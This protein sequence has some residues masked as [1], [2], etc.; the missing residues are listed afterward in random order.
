MSTLLRT[1]PNQRSPLTKPFVKTAQLSAL[2]DKIAD[3]GGLGILVG[4]SVRDH[5][6][7]LH[8]KDLD[9]EVYGLSLAKLESLLEKHFQVVAVGKAFGIFKVI[10]NH[11]GQKQSFDVALPRRENKQG[12]GHKGFIVETDEAMSFEEAS[13]RR[14]FTVNAMGIDVTR[15]ELLDAHGGKSDLEHSIL[16]HVSLAF[17]EDPLRVLRAAQ[18]CARFGFS[19]EQSTVLLCQELKDELKTLSKERI[20]EEMKKLLFSKKPS[21]GMSVLRETKAL[22]LFP[23]LEALIDCQQDPLWHPEGDVWIH[24]LMVIDEAA[25]ICE[26]NDLSYEDKLIVMTGALCHDLGKPATTILKDDRIKSP[27]HDEAGVAITESLLSRMAFP[28]KLT[29]DI[30]SLVREHL[31]PYQLYNKRDNVSDGAIRRLAHRVNIE[32]LLLVSQADFFGRTTEEAKSGIDPSASWL[33]DRVSALLGA[34]MAPKPLLLGRHLIDLGYKP[35]PD[36]SRILNLAFE[37]QLDGAFQT[38]EEALLWLKEHF[39]GPG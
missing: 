20:F 23:E 36:F 11:E 39:P 35:G 3:A 13:K 31:K 15:E 9:I 1:T 22:I 30:T 7:G 25:R 38:Q 4:G 6:L 26:E 2:L 8:P 32:R 16:R 12:Q 33:K 34:D 37:A 10:V 5:L 29:D 21:R 14:D 17:A 18:F 28:P 19:L 27:G 24:T